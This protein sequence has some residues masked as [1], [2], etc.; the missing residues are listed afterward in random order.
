[1]RERRNARDAISR[2]YL[3]APFIIEIIKIPGVR[4][5]FATYAAGK[6]NERYQENWCKNNKDYCPE[7][8]PR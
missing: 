8:I 7:G 2:L 1:M 5:T 6:N 4:D 3:E